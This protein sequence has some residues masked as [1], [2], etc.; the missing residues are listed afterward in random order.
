MGKARRRRRDPRSL[1]RQ[2]K[3]RATPVHLDRMP[4]AP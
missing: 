3:Q 4:L 1:T 2:A